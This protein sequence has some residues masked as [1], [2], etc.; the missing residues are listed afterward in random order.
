MDKRRI[1]LTFGTLSIVGLLGA[2]FLR[3]SVKAKGTPEAACQALGARPFGGPLRPGQQAP[4]FEL[5]DAAGKNWSLAGLRGKPVLLNFWATWCAPCAKEMPSIERISRRL[6][7]RLTV[8]TVSVDE[9][10]DAVKAFFPAG[11]NLPVL[12]DSGEQVTRRYGTEKFPE[13]FLIDSAGRLQQLF[14]QADWDAPEAE[15]C[16]ASLR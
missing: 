7:D 8:L 16:L 3:A 10:W 1:A 14:Y 4:D 9:S 11:T 2:S 6:G 15:G 5:T 13:T 12:L